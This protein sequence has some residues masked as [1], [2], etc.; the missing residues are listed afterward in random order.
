VIPILAGLAATAVG[1]LAFTALASRV[2]EAR[3]P[4]VGER[5]TAGPRGGAVHVVERAPNPPVRG[6]VLLVHGASGNFADL[7]V[8]LGE[9]LAALGFRVFAVD[10]PSHGW[11]DRLAG[12]DAASP[13]GQ[14]AALRAVLA[15]RGVERAIVVVHSLAGMLGL[16]MALDAP[17]FTQG[18]VLL[19]PVSHPWPGGVA[20]YYQL[21]AS[22]LFGPAFRRLFVLPAG[23]ASM[24]G[25]VGE[26]FAP[27]PPPRDYAVATRLPLVFRPHHFRANAEDVVAA[28]AH[29]AA[30]SPRYPTIRVPTA[31]VTGDHDGVVYAKIHSAGCARDIPGAKLTA[32]SGVGHSPHHSAP[33]KVVAAILEVE[34]RALSEERRQRE[35]APAPA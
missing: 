14:A 24:R 35:R 17:G 32:L 6:A 27:N 8:A 13:A 22:R 16:A 25:G 4:P 31:I 30:L 21:A 18:L 15:L 19:A 28:E 5:L 23:L 1:L 3:F 7:D 33:D 10:R 2:I 9:R 20:W 34:G 29:V 26:V 11:S 12:A